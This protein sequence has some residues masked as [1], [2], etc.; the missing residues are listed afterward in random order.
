[1]FAQSIITDPKTNF[2]W[3]VK[4]LLNTLA[5]KPPNFSPQGIAICTKNV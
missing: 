3:I 4:K 2:Q 1:M 5:E